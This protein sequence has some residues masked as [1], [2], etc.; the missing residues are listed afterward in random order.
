[1]IVP[2]REK[3][4]KHVVRRRDSLVLLKESIETSLPIVISNK[5]VV[6]S[7]TV[8]YEYVIELW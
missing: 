6:Q 7:P 2:E 8:L 5:T 1:M 4:G 3:Y